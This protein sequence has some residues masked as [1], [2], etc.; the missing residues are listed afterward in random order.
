[1]SVLDEGSLDQEFKNIL[2]IETHWNAK[3]VSKDRG[4][5]SRIQLLKS[6]ITFMEKQGLIDYDTKAER[7]Y[8]TQRLSAIMQNFCYSERERVLN[9]LAVDALTFEEETRESEMEDL[10]DVLLDFNMEKASDF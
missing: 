7:L 9:L 8:P 3:L 1:M 10:L 5:T 6:V 4:Q 2:D